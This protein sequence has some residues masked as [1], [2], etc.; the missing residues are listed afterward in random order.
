MMFHDLSKIK[1]IGKNVIIG[2]F[3]KIVN[4]ENI[5]IDDFSRIDDFSILV[6]G[7]G[8]KIG[9][10][11][12][13]ASYCSVI[14]GGEF[15]MEDFSGLSAGVR[16]VTGSDDYTGKCLTNP[17]VPIKY[18]PLAMKG[19]IT[20]KKHAIIGTNSVIFP[21]ITIG[22]GAAIGAASVVNKNVDSWGIY[23]GCPAKKIKERESETILKMEKE[24]MA[25]IN[26]PPNVSD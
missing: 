2:D 17:T 10:F 24:L 5:E 1:K 8:L 7:N 19:S 6:G 22:E 14:G 13:I 26:T 12:H 16:I 23:V 11:V 3:V 20:I 21:N 9:K 15:I 4:P 18:R 25:E